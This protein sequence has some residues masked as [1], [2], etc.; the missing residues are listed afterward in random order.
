M[1]GKLGEILK[2]LPVAHQVL[3]GIGVAVLGMASFLFMQW[4]STPSY[5]LLYGGL[6]DATLA[7]VVDELERGGTSY[8][9]EAGGSRVMVPQSEVHR[10]R[11]VETSARG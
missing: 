2:S 7:Q 8:R 1:R 4:V 9:I 6:D 5:T 3:I 11:Q 10:A